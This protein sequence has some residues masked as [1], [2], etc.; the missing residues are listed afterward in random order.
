MDAGNHVLD[1]RALVERQDLPRLVKQRRAFLHRTLDIEVSRTMEIGALNTPTVRPDE[2]DTDFLDWF[3]TEELR[4]KHATNR[5]V[6]TNDIVHVDH[7]VKG[8][9]IHLAT[10]DRYDLVLASH[11]LEHIPDPISWLAELE[12]LVGEGGRLFLSV[13]DRRFT[14]DYFRT[15]SD[16]VDVVRAFEEE[17]E[18]PSSY[19]IAKHLYYFQD[20]S[21]TAAWSGEIPQRGTPRIS[22]TEAI[23]KS[24]AL[25]MEYTDVHCWVFTQDS[26]REVMNDLHDGGYVRWTLCEFGDVEEGQNEFRTL[27]KL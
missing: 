11:V 2:C 1:K 3:S 4:V 6:N 10:E 12:S 13:P 5:T 19:Q 21:C 7:V 26:F 22:F 8:K 24:K 16:A 23:E 15:E 20:L 18:R 27:L 25:A 17:L 14:F 9:K